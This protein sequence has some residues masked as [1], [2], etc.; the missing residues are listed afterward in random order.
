MVFI[1]TTESGLVPEGKAHFLVTDVE[2]GEDRITVN[3]DILAHENDLAC[4]RQVRDMFSLSG[5][6]AIRGQHFALAT[7]L[8]TEDD[9]KASQAAGRGGIDIDFEKARLS[10]FCGTTKWSKDGK[11]CN[12]A[13]DYKRTDS[14]EA[15]DYPKNDLFLKKPATKKTTKAAAKPTATEE[16]EVF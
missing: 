13:W 14:P 1:D 2:I 8:I 12:V 5:K 6:F 11:Y 7:G 3:L 16:A 10:T 15:K 4:G 9:V